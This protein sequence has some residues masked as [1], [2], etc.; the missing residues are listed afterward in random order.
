MVVDGG[1]GVADWL[2]TPAAQAHDVL[3]RNREHRAVFDE[4]R[5]LFL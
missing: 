5:E 2:L 4:Q 1:A 3:R